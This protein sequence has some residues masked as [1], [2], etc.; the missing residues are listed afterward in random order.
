MIFNLTQFNPFTE[1]RDY[2]IELLFKWMPYAHF[3]TFFAILPHMRHMLGALKVKKI[4]FWKI[5]NGRQC[6]Y[7]V[8]E[9][10]V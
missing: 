2:V 4:Q 7:S 1:V 8:P 5:E 3:D 9:K 6:P 10:K